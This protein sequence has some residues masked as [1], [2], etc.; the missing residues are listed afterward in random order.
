[1]GRQQALL[2][3][4][5]MVSGLY[6]LL[7]F[8]SVKGQDKPIPSADDPKLLAPVSPISECPPLPEQAPESTVTVY[9]AKMPEKSG[10]VC[11]RAVNGIHPSVSFNS[12]L[13]QQRD[14]G[15]FH[16]FTE[17]LP[18]TPPGI[19]IGE[20]AVHI[21]LMPGQWFDRQFPSFSP[22]PPGTYRACFRYTLYM[23][24][25]KQEVCSEEVS[26]P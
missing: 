1:M 12:F 19:I 17:P 13:L 10:F 21:V 7:G 23:S 16:D 15:Q 11:A 25:E 2:S 20:E 6:L 4:A 14:E 26:L 24:T 22:A 5:A 8:S 9:V 18:P 3:L